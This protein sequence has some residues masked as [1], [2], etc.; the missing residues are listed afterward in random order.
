MA[1]IEQ[2]VQTATI[3]NPLAELVTDA[4]VVS[5]GLF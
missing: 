3:R 4:L 5:F 1:L 2:Q